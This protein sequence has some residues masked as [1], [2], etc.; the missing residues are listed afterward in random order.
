MLHYNYRP[1][2]MYYDCVCGKRFTYTG[3]RIVFGFCCMGSILAALWG[4]EWIAVRRDERLLNSITTE[5]VE[6]AE[7]YR[8]SFTKS[9]RTE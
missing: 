5:A 6:G 1:G 8:K 7:G 2:Y 9:D 3:N 4:P